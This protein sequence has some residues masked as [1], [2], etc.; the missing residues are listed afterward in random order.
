MTNY[1]PDPAILS[2]GPDFY[3]PVEPA[4]FPKC[5]PRF[6]N[7]RWAERLG[8][9]ELD[10]AGRFCRFEPLSENLPQPLGAALSRPSVPR[11]QSRHR[12]RPRLPVRAASRRRTAACSTSAPRARARRRTAGIGDGRLTLKGGVR[13]VLATEM[14]EALG[15]KTSKSFALIET[16]EELERG[17]EPSPTRSAVLVRLQPRPHPHRH[18]PAPRLLRRDRQSADADALLPCATSTAS[19]RGRRPRQR[20][21]LLDLVAPATAS[22]RRL[23]YR[24]RASSTACSISDNINVTGESFD[25]G[26]WR[27]TPFGTPTSPPPISTIT[28]STPSAA[29]PRR[30]TGTSPSSPAACADRRGEPLVRPCS[31]ASAT[32]SKQAL[33]DAIFARLGLDP[34]DRTSDREA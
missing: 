15:V 3:D 17:D 10:W 2:L 16:G 8:L 13:E 22:A 11:V 18:L 20:A 21:P 30:S 25:Y 29:S 6:L 32:A 9:D 31:T 27:F 14:L 26:P 33:R 24:R 23:L 34:G 19:R 1:R 28:A 4:R 12:R 5:I 7:H